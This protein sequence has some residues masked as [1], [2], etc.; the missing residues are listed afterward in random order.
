MGPGVNV[1]RNLS[2]GPRI[3]RPMDGARH[4]LSGRALALEV[5][6]RLA[7]VFGCPIEYFDRL[8]PMAE[9]ISSYL[10][11]RTRNRDARL[12]FDALR[13][14]FPSWEAVRDAP[15]AEVKRLIGPCTWP[16]RKAPG[17]QEILRQV[18]ARSGGYDLGFLGQ[19]PVAEARAWLED[20]PGVGPKTSAATLSFSTLRRPALPVDS[21]HHRV[22]QRI[23]LIPEKMSVGP[24]HAV[25]QGFVPAD[26][27]AQAVYDHHQVFMRLG[28]RTC[29][30]RRPD[31]ARCPLLDL[32]PT[33]QGGGDDAPMEEPR[34]ARLL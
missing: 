25:L 30:W 15:V 8:D 1:S 10:N 24:S 18:E 12:A 14:A 9:L 22:A 17:V 16:E 26:W 34:Q 23:G 33:G 31:C 32:C 20:L 21:H 7:P 11:H 3:P 5:H 28:Q 6:R 13:E 27:D 29:H 2:T 4:I 19:M